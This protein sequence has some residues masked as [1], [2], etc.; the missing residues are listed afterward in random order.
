M[1]LR[2]RG[3]EAMFLARTAERP[4][5]S[6]VPFSSRSEDGCERLISVPPVDHFRH[7]QPDGRVVFEHFRGLLE[8]FRP[9][10]VHFHHYVHL[11][12]EFIRE[13]RKF[14]PDVAII[15]TLHEF[16]AICHAQGQ[17]LK[18]NG[19]LCKKASPH[20]CHLCFPDISPQDFFMRE[21]FV[22]SFFNL[23]DQFVCPSR[24]LSERY[25]AWGIPAEKIVVLE[26]GQPAREREVPQEAQTSG[27]ERR[28]VVIGQ[29]SRLKGTFVLLDAV[30]LLPEAVRKKVR[31]E[32]HGSTQYADNEFKTKL[33]NELKGLED[34]VRLHGPYMPEHV[35]GIIRG[36]G[37]VIVPSI[38]WENSPLV[39]QEAF[40]AGRPVICSDIGGMAEKVADG[41]SGF[42]FRVN[43][44]AD[45]AAR[46]EQCAGQPELWREMCARLPQPPSIEETVDKL[47]ALYANGR[48]KTNG[49]ASD[50]RML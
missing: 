38:W 47:L 33:A 16:L 12:L 9:T 7:S 37:W 42:H 10:A 11:G 25:Q 18:T 21:L 36:N 26:N 45:L 22:K 49:H 5:H 40:A 50:T 34:T 19:L 1:E 23:V 2:R 29:L 6:G 13:V 14:G 30:R 4:E 24:F 46:I 48:P 43:N 31:I 39:I 35:T 44:A 28:F 8:R 17:M 20:D 32:L 27:R 41:S 3:V 15:V